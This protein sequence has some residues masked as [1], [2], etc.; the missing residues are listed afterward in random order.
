MDLIHGMYEI[1]AEYGKDDFDKK[2]QKRIRKNCIIS[3]FIGTV[4]IT[5]LC[6]IYEKNNLL[7]VI[8]IYAFIQYFLYMSYSD[9]ITT[10]LKQAE[11]QHAHKSEIDYL[12]HELNNSY[13][14]KSQLEAKIKQLA[15]T[16]R[17]AARRLIFSLFFAR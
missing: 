3:F 10:I 17:V 13:N 5:I 16:T 1:F 8:P 4:A 11:V 9:K 6:G 2:T 12:K 14:E 7:L 15:R